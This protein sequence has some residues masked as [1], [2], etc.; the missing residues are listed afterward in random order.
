MRASVK[1]KKLHSR[2]SFK[3]IH[4]SPLTVKDVRQIPGYENVS[5]EVAQN[6]IEQIENFAEILLNLT[7]YGNKRKS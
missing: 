6:M 5:E 2:K 1:T 3:P 7:M 4:L